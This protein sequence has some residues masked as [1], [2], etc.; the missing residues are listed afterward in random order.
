MAGVRLADIKLKNIREQVADFEDQ[1]RHLEIIA[2]LDGIVVPPPRIEA[3]KMADTKNQLATWYGTPL[4][5]QNRDCYLEERTHLLSIAPNESY[6]AVLVVDQGDRDRVE[7][8]QAVQ[9]KFDHLPTRVYEGTISS[10][11]PQEMEFA[12]KELSNKSGGELAT[13]TDE[14]GREKLLSTAYPA[15]VELTQ[16]TNLLR[17]GMRGKSR[18]V[19]EDRSAA[20]WIYRY[21][22]RTFHFHL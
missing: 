13:V 22:R 6:E 1:I 15:T 9:I 14:H 16:D 18:F 2:P 3:P 19:V 20:E 4:D 12:P 7:V 21:F 11:S 8:G 10:I 17:T 5:V